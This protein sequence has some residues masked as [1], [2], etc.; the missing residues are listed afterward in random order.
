VRQ[1][2]E[3]P[4]DVAELKTIMTDFESVEPEWPE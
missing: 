4:E 1:L 2:N 3:N